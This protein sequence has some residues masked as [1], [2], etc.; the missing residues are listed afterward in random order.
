MKLNN[1]DLY[2]FYKEKNINYLYHANT[3]GT[4][5]TYFQQNG[6]LS[7]GAVEN[8]GLF[9]TSQSSDDIDKIL[10]VWDDVFID[11]TDLHSYFNRQNHYGPILFEFLTE[12]IL[13]ENYEF[14]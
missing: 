11:T 9:Q 13:N 1:K 5:I 14:G 3:V 10:G 12:L 8:K 7:R 4:T 6:I 2:N